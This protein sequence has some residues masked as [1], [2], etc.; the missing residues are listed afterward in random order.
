[1]SHLLKMEE[2]M[3]HYSQHRF[4]KGCDNMELIMVID[5]SLQFLYVLHLSLCT[6]RH[7]SKTRVFMR[8]FHHNLTLYILSHPM[9]MKTGV[10][11]SPHPF[12][13]INDHTHFFF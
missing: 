13:L 1:M 2:K 9:M 5:C 8:G 3:S 10:R 6:Q 12:M 4:P 7:S 11:L